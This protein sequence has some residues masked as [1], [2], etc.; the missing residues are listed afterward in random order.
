[1]IKMK[2]NN[3]NKQ[4]GKNQRQMR[5]SDS[6][7]CKKQGKGKSTRGRGNYNDR[8]Y[9]DDSLDPK[10]VVSTQN[11][12]AWY[13][14]NPQLMRDYASFPFGTPLGSGITAFDTPYRSE[15]VPGVMAIHF[16]PALPVGNDQVSAVNTAM[17]NIYTFVR[18][19]NSGHTNYDAP[20]LMMYLLAM[21]SMYMYIEYLKRLV[22]IALA[23][24][25]TNRYYPRA[26][27]MANGVDPDDIMANLPALRGAV[28]QFAVK[29][30][31]LCVPNSM[32]Y[33]ARHAWMVSTY[34]IDSAT[35]KSQTYM[36][37]PRYFYKAVPNTA[38]PTTLQMQTLLNDSVVYS[39]ASA[40]LMK[41]S[42]LIAFGNS[43]LTPII[44]S[45][46]FNVMSGDILKA[47]GDSGV[48]KIMGVPDGY[49]VMPTYSQEV[50][51]Q[52]ENATIPLFGALNNATVTQGTGV[53]EGFLSYSPSV[54]V[55]TGM[56]YGGAT[57]VP[58]SGATQLALYQQ[59]AY[60]FDSKVINMH[61]GGVTPEEIMVA[62]RLATVFG[63]PSDTAITNNIQ[64]NGV[65]YGWMGLPVK[66]CGSEIATSAVIYCL[67][68]AGTLNAYPIGYYMPMSLNTE[69][70]AA[71]GSM[72]S[73]FTNGITKVSTF[74]W[75][76][77]IAPTIVF[78][79]NNAGNITSS[80]IQ[81][82]D[83]L[84]LICDIDNFTILSKAN[85]AQLND[86]ALL[87]EFSV[88]QMGAFSKRI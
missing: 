2:G 18:H 64:Y 85:L 57:S 73:M 60:S 62:T 3:N 4:K 10:E 41:V 23:Y 48:V 68:S 74:D 39:P 34:F 42:S 70:S 47:F 78:G 61:H 44:T 9:R 46:D 1:M 49:L 17:R 87:S 19:V 15:N 25:P 65:K 43:L 12:A 31:S 76:P 63:A 67:N 75:A 21:D 51:S 82:A 30:G 37:V 40:T 79:H 11:D 33:M 50:L 27:F 56:G 77:Q 26:L 28:N 8:K 58:S 55:A 5:E 81:S 20:D 29:V 7:S 83:I 38:N 72:L 22:G 32:S 14:Q 69:N 45:E 80:T 71:G 86:V 54:F 53:G 16:G 66:S 52:I 24:T 6:K 35:D 36:F 13:A 59:S 88:P 84:G